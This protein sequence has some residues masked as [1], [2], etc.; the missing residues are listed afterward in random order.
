MRSVSLFILLFWGS[1]QTTFAQDNCQRS[2]C[3]WEFFELEKTIKGEVIHHEYL[4]Q[5]FSCRGLNYNNII[6]N[7]NSS[8]QLNSYCPHLHCLSI[9]ILK[10][11]E[12]TIRVLN[13]NSD[14]YDKG[15]QLYIIPDKIIAKQE[16]NKLTFISHSLERT[17][18]KKKR[19]WRKEY[20]NALSQ[21][22]SRYDQL[23]LRTTIG[24][25]SDLS[26]KERSVFDC[27]EKLFKPINQNSFQCLW[28]FFEI[29][30]PLE[31]KIIKY[32]AQM[33]PCH[34]IAYASL[35]IVAINNNQDT[36]RV[37]SCCDISTFKEGTEV[38]IEAGEYK[39]PVFIP[40]TKR[41]EKTQEIYRSNEFDST[42]FR[43]TY[44]K[45]INKQ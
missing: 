23:V 3:D 42:V 7:L 4:I 39:S 27:E 2:Y 19:G 14:W 16:R 13:S 22:P 31:G 33:Q 30:E 24:N 29:E 40:Y 8:Y 15:T 5:R 37:L 21:L 18:V 10:V 17:V 1:I 45:I 12:D 32:Q 28:N 11:N 9:T 6:R 20:K 43:T 41:I 34:L 36:I 26:D 25:L 38:L 44:G 35:A